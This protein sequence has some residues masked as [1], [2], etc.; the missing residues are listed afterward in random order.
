MLV[1]GDTPKDITAAHAA[2]AIGVGVASGHYSEAE[3]RQARAD[4]VLGSL[5]EDLPGTAQATV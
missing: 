5:E 3:L 2:N 1:V 4:Y